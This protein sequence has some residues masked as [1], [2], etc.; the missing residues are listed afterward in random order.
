MREQLSVA[1][2]AHDARNHRVLLPALCHNHV[3]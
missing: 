2:I 3:L 1:L